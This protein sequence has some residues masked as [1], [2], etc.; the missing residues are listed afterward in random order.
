MKDPILKMT[1]KDFKWDYFKVPGHGG[2]KKNKTS[3]ACRCT[4]EASGAVGTASESRSQ[5]ENR[6]M[7]FKRMAETKEFQ[8]WARIETL[9]KAH[10][11]EQIEKQ[12]DSDLSNPNITIVEVK[13][14]QGR[15]IKDFEPKKEVDD[16]A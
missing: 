1:A 16:Y 10:V 4:H 13:D 9:K 6:E 2:Q 12:I 14:G 15:W 7:A 3:S 5:R 11:V 8:Q